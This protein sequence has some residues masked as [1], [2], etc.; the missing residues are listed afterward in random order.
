MAKEVSVVGNKKVATLMDEFSNKFPYLLLAIFP[1]SEKMKK[2]QKP[3]SPD[4]SISEIRTMV[5]PGHISIHGR[6]KVNNLEE[7]FEKIFGLYAQVCFERSDGRRF[8]TSGKYDAMSLTEINR[9]GEDNGW[10]KWK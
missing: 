1:L 3:Y 5:N 8:F 7:D 2:T 10:K 4:K 9:Y 6:T